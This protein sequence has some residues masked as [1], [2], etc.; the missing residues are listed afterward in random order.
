[1]MARIA[2]PTRLLFVGLLMG[3]VTAPPA[4]AHIT[5]F[6]VDGEAQLSADATSAIVTGLV[7]CDTGEEFSVFALVFEAIAKGEAVAGQGASGTIV[8]TGT[9]QQVWTVTV[10]VA[11]PVGAKF[12]PGQAI[13]LASGTSFDPVVLTHTDSSGILDVIHLRK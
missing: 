3:L 11:L 9:T 6:T 7:V 12:K 5:E 13:V 8:C 2:I 1:M 10:L 4:L